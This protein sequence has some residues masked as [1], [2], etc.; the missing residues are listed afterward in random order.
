MALRRF[1]YRDDSTIDD[2]LGA[3]ELGVAESEVR[4]DEAQRSGKASVEIAGFGIGGDRGSTHGVERNVRQT[5]AS[6]VEALFRLL[7][8][9][10]PKELWDLDELDQDTWNCLDKGSLINLEVSIRI[11]TVS[12]ALGVAQDLGPLIQVMQAFNPELVDADTSRKMGG[13]SQ[14][15]TAGGAKRLAVAAH[16]TSDPR[17]GFVCR[18][19]QSGLLVPFESLEGERYLFGQIEEMI[20]VG[21]HELAIDM[22]GL[23][24]LNRQ[25]RREMGKSKGSEMADAFVKGPAAVVHVIS[26]YK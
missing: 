22:A 24:V 6:K 18:M 3:L 4:R 26:L 5:A 20:P 8:Q 13:L 21:Q 15:A 11:P 19:E 1:Q 23:G 16:S 25:Q 10:E 17:F 7:T 9:Q 12:R 14:F 2:F